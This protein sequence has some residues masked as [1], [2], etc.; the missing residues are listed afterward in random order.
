MSRPKAASASTRTIKKA[1]GALFQ[2]KVTATTKIERN[3][4]EVPLAA[5]MVGDRVQAR[6]N[7]QTI[8]ASKVE[9]KSP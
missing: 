4:R 7:P 8:V 6:F 1:G 3:G 9:A 5:L 2:V